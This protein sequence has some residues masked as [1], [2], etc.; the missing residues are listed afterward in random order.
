[1]GRAIGRHWL[2]RVRGY[3]VAHDH[4]EPFAQ[5]RHFDPDRLGG[6]MPPMR[7]DRPGARLAD[8]EAYLVKQFLIHTAAPRDCRGDQSRGP[9]VGR[10]RSERNLDRGHLGK[11]S[12][13]GLLL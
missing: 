10:Q 3:R 2:R 12:P 9:Y 5:V 13:A 1:M 11:A 8:G 4:L 7:L 6:A